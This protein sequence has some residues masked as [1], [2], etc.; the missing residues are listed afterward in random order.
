LLIGERVKIIDYINRSRAVSFKEEPKK[1]N[2][3][4]QYYLGIIL[5][6][7]EDKFIL[8]V[9]YGRLFKI[10]STYNV[11]IDNN[12]AIDVFVDIAN[13]LLGNYFYLL[14][15]KHKDELK[16]KNYTFSI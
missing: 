12:R 7:L 8:S 4:I 13:D 5:R 16:D 15:K 6:K 2:D 11:S 10:I 1:I 14:Y 9:I 3:F